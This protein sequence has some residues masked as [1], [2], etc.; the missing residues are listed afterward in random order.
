MRVYILFLFSLFL[1]LEVNSQLFIN[2]F[3]SSNVNGLLDEDS[4]YSDWIEIYNAG[5]TSV[6]L[7]GYALSDVF[8]QP[9]KWIFP[10]ISV[11]SHGY[12]LVFASGKDRYDL[13]LVYQTITDMGDEWRY[14]VP[15]SDLGT[16]WLHAGFDDS[17]WSIGYSGFGYSD[18]DDS[19][20]LPST[21]SVFLRKEFTISDLGSIQRIVFSIDY[22]DAFV[23][24]INGKEIARAN[25]GIAGQP[26]AFD[27][28]AAVGHEAVMYTGGMP[29]NYLINVPSDFL[30]EGAN[31]LAVQGHNSGI[32]STDMTVIPFLTIGRLGTGVSDV[33]P[34][35]ALPTGK[36][37]HTNFKINSSGEGFYLFNSVGN[38]VD[39]AGAVYL[40]NDVSYGR[41]PN[42]SSTWLYFGEPTPG[43]SNS[44]SGV[45]EVIGH[46]VTFAPTGGK[47]LGGVTISLSTVNSSDSIYY[48]TDG[49]IPDE[50]DTRYTGP[51]YMGSSRVIRARVIKYNTLPGPVA[52]NTY[53]ISLNHDIP[54]IGLS[55]EPA[56]LWDETT[57][58]YAYGPNPGDYPYFGANFWQDWERP[59]HFE[60]Y[61]VNGTKRLDQ[62]AGIKIYGAWSRASEQKSFALFARKEYGEG[63]FEYKFFA[64]KNIDKF[65]SFVLRN[66]GNDNMG[67]Q[68]QDCFLTG[69]VR[70]MNVDRQA[71][72]PA[73]I[74][75]NGEYWGLLNIREKINEHFL[76]ENHH[77]NPDSVN[78]LEFGGDVILGTN[79]RYLALIDYLNTHS[80]LQDNSEYEWVSNQMDIDNYIQYQLTQIYIN[81]RDWPG[82]NIK[83]WNTT[84]LDSKWRWI[85]FDTDFGF[86]IWD[87]NDYMLNTLGFALYPNGNDWPNP[88][89]STLLF[90]RM[91]TNLDFRFNFITQYCDRL[92]LDFHPDRINADLDSLK[93]L[94]NWEIV[95][96]FNRWWG[97]YQEWLARI[98]DRK[99]FGQNRPEYC[100]QHLQYEFGLGNE[101]E[102]T[103]D[104][105][106]E[107]A[108]YIR[109]NTIEPK[110]YPFTGIY[111]EDIPIKMTAVPKPGYK[112]VKWEGTLNS[113]EVTITY[114]MLAEGSFR[115]VFAS[116]SSADISIVV[117]E[118]NYNSAPERDTKD[119]IEIM[120]NGNTS[121]D[122]NGWLLSDSGP[123]SGY[124]FPSGNVLSPGEYLV[125]CRDLQDFKDFNPSVSNAIGDLPFG[126][127]SS[128]D[129][130]RLYD[131]ESDLAD[132]VDYYPFNP[133]PENANGTGASI[134]L[135]NPSLDNTKGENWQAIGIGGTPGKPN[136]GYLDVPA[137][138]LPNPITSAFE[139]FPNPFRD[140]TTIQFTVV[141]EGNY[142]LEV[143]DMSGRIVEVLS[144]SYLTE[145]T[146]WIDWSRTTRSGE[147]LNGGVYT[148]R[149]SKN[150]DVETIK[151]IMLK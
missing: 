5:G 133:W 106:D 132:A 21:I 28:A 107:E 50:T 20:V 97:T 52:S 15:G 144:D 110:V 135:I 58:I 57:G 87:V 94:Y 3:L 68:F 82:N 136:F 32:S 83:F 134:E 101:M 103:L 47:H 46:N 117:N 139:C 39:S 121:V 104:V 23:A 2:E 114:D 151:V 9:S 149:L 123:D 138:S 86:G 124:F 140:Y 115:A 105:S 143:L 73:A 81:N 17:A 109:L 4:E 92:N 33:S 70:E 146:Y 45:E 77:V 8:T 76:A 31:I 62:D 22:D 55:T 145:G 69:L 10:G 54:I 24:Y 60:F 53:V 80:N 36:E 38:L 12:L 150:S 35:L 126:L 89:W 7:S 85:L 120:N 13:P 90:R 56:N 66:S 74:Y 96:H 98:S 6:N 75:L 91:V 41:K 131:A 37:L 93:D 119:W 84:S 112:F 42:G 48:T 99:I 16:S 127:S 40:M 128:G 130:I 142:K 72:Q 59:V 51:F 26:V 11:P 137:I 64:D 49:S 29:E 1:A 100:R 14:L 95:Y 125:V 34:Y 61:D 88:A 43:S 102:I 118:I 108:G 67:L 111:F 78:L 30:V 63:S 65:E 113:P 44:T 79:E 116:A 141:L 71:F 122:L 25:I 27:Q 18:D 147:D 129:M 19:T 148:I